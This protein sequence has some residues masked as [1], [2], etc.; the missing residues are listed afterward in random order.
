MMLVPLKDLKGPNGELEFN[1]IEERIPVVKAEHRL[2]KVLS[3]K[4][5]PNVKSK[6]APKAEVD[7]VKNIKSIQPPLFDNIRL[8]AGVTVGEGV[9]RRRSPL[10]PDVKTM[11]R[12]HYRS[13]ADLYDP[14][15]HLSYASS[16]SSA[17]HETKSRE[18]FKSQV[19]TSNAGLLSE[20]PDIDEAE[21]RPYEAIQVMP[22]Q[23]KAKRSRVLPAISKFG[24]GVLQSG[25]LSEID[26]FNF[27]LLKSKQWGANP[28][29]KEPIVFNKLPQRPSLKNL[30]ETY[31]F[32]SKLP[33]DR[34]YIETTARTHLSPQHGKTIGQGLMT[35]RSELLA[36]V[37]SSI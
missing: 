7:F 2:T 23:M 17:L 6:K 28:P 37:R 30:Q 27:E 10:K 32:R 33:R 4:E 12:K 35:K 8:A 13:L 16:I 18:E 22:V 5:L 15:T 19:V 25:E 3:A 26:K 34:P 29:I 9:R 24:E 21:D 1:L 20:I 31:G 36:S 11:T 14:N